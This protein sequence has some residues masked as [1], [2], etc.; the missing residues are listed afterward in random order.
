MHLLMLE[1]QDLEKLKVENKF[2]FQIMMNF[3]QMILWNYIMIFKKIILILIKQK[4][5]KIV[6][7][8]KINNI[9]SILKLK[10]HN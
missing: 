2:H 10:I 3:Y 6:N 7:Q 9:N 8:L 5:F 4:N 1:L